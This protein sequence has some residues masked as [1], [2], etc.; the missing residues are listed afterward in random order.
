[1]FSL[2][3]SSF[4]SFRIYFFS[5]DDDTATELLKSAGEFCSEGQSDAAKSVFQTKG[6]GAMF[7][8]AESII[9]AKRVRVV[10]ADSDEDA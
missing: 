5:Q 2:P 7:Q 9:V 6:V 4:P 3:S 10:E 8:G 1:M